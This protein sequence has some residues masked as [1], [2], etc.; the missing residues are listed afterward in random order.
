MGGINF[1]LA[2]NEKEGKQIMYQW[3]K[4]SPLVSLACGLTLGLMIGVGMLVGALVATQ[5][6]GQLQVDWPDVPLHAMASH[7]ESG[8]TLATGPV[9]ED[10]EGVFILDHLTGDLQCWVPSAR[11]PGSFSGIFNHNVLR[12]LGVEGDKTPKFVMVTGGINFRGATGA[13]RP[14]GTLVYVADANSG[15]VAVYSIPWNR[16]MASSGRAQSGSLVLML[17]GKGRNAAI[18]EPVGGVPVQP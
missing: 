13:T 2:F 6:S 4:K 14:A 12:D 10:A 11:K 1:S 7:G 9:D 8:I 5:S 16:S 15:N 17:T 18:R 3:L